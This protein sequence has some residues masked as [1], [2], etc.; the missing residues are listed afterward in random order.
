M[1]IYVKPVGRFTALYMAAIDPFRRLLVYPALTRH[2]QQCWSRAF[3]YH[4]TSDRP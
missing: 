4:A 1:A 3:A 2:A